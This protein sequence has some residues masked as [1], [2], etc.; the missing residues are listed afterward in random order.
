MSYL[1]TNLEKLKKLIILF[2][3]NCIM[4][5]S[6]FI[7]RIRSI[8]I[9][10]TEEWL[11]IKDENDAFADVFVSYAGPLI[12]LGSLSTFINNLNSE[13]SL[14]GNL[15]TAIIYFLS[16]A[17]SLYLSIYTINELTVSFGLEK[18]KVFIEKLVIFS[19]TAFYIAEAIV[20]LNNQLGLL[21]LFSFYSLYL[22][23]TGFD[24]FYDGFEK[25]KMG[26]VIISSF[27]IFVSYIV[28][29]YLLSPALIII[30]H[31]NL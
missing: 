12:S 22:F 23:W 27:I 10:P 3:L 15:A 18:N 21:G 6:I 19:S 8:L 20:H 29:Q 26:F 17:G 25:R 7:K 24:A 1:T 5:F 30:N 2:A 14:I 13:Y 11:K 28:L 31:F 4:D 9:K 16:M